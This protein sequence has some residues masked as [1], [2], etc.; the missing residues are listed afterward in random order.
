MIQINSEI[1]NKYN[2]IPVEMKH[3][4]QWVGFIRTPIIKNGKA[5][6]NGDGTPRMSKIP[7]DVHTFSGA[8]S[9]KASQWASFNE[10][11]NA[12][13]K[14]ATV[15]DKSG[16][17]EGIGF[18]FRPQ[19]DTDTGICGIDLDHIINPNTGEINTAA[20]DI[21][22][23]MD[24]YTEY[25]PSGTGVHIYYYG[26]N[27]P[28]WKNKI[29]G[30]LGIGTCLEMYQTARYFTVTGKVFG[31]P[32]P[33][34][35]REIQAAEIQSR[36]A[37]KPQEKPIIAPSVEKYAI[38]ALSD[39]EVIDK[40]SKSK[41]GTK[42]TALLGGDL[43]DYNNDQSRA[44]QALCNI[45]A[46]WC[47]GDTRQMDRIFRNSGLMREKWDEK[48]GANT[49]GEITL[50][51]A[52][53]KCKEFYSPNYKRTKAVEDF[54]QMLPSGNM[55]IRGIPDRTVQPLP[56]EN[57]P[58]KET[59]PNNLSEEFEKKSE[60][61]KELAKT[62][63]LNSKI[64]KFCQDYFFDIDE[65][66]EFLEEFVR[67]FAKEHK[68]LSD[69][70]DKKKKLL[71]NISNNRKKIEEAERVEQYN[72]Q[73]QEM[74]SRLPNWIWL[75]GKGKRHLD[76]P[77]FMKIFAAE[78][79]LK[80]FSGN[81]YEIDGY[82]TELALSQKIQ[83]QLDL[84]FTEKIAQLTK[85]VVDG[86]KN[87]YF[88]EDIPPC[89][90]QI[91][92]H[93]GY[94]TTDG[95]GLFTVFIP[96]K[97]FCLNRL[98][99]EYSGK[100][101][102]P[103]MFLKYLN[104]VY[105]AEDIRT[106]QQ[107]LGYCCLATNRLQLALII[108]G[109][110]EEGKSQLGEIVYDIVGKKNLIQNKIQAVQERFG[111]ANCSNKL[112]YID[113]DTDGKALLETG[114]F[115]KLVTSKG[116]MEAEKK[117]VQQN[118]GQFYV[119]FLCFG[120]NV[121]EALYDDSDGFRRRL[122]ILQARPKNKNRKNIKDLAEKI[123]DK[124]KE[125]IFSWLLDGLNDLIKNDWELYIS[126]TSKELS[127]KLKRESDTVNLFFTDNPYIEL[128]KGGAIHT[129]DLYTQYVYWCDANALK[130]VTQQRFAKTVYER[131]EDYK[132]EYAPQLCLGNK[133][134]RGYRGITFNQ[135]YTN[136]LADNSSKSTGEKITPIRTA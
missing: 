3:L 110:G 4:P 30:A 124:E 98:N 31:E 76:E 114:N 58:S 109:K 90:N 112:L 50:N 57:E 88:V 107:Y 11:V 44:D 130:N 62:E 127:E 7:V 119:R 61:V 82:I 104:E 93:N 83:Q 5:E 24:S 54:K 43:S 63:P 29:E 79:Q 70:K 75:D 106:I 69:F 78:H 86:L 12:I 18:V 13:G 16:T 2:S 32:K 1:L 49:Y 25:S 120:N 136:S 6:F 96:H 28:E 95:D 46:F 72:T 34:A 26:A 60:E 108:H 126:D 8:S 19:K 85:R 73:R 94:F 103:T 59:T 38:T 17:V 41:S 22:K 87:K 21:I 115:K 111:L 14:T 92:I 97:E 40:A 66:E 116:E 39:D 99:V 123:L 37:P 20:L 131:K 27:H 55:T 65:A 89:V 135:A 118:S 56:Q 101:Q 33:I 77:L 47:S 53:A 23:S 80:Y 129:A 134:A 133:R 122:L 71:K 105:K 81:F 48:R 102:E 35:E 128:G 64:Y 15:K 91:H 42:F 45:L 51:E 125:S 52:V 36:H 67:P 68:R 74:Q 132:I 9:T 100:K 84:Y 121:L 10:A 113:D 117:N